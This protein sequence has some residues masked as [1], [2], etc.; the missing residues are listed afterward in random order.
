[1][2]RISPRQGESVMIYC[3]YGCTNAQ[4]FIIKYNSSD[5][6]NPEEQEN[7]HM[8]MEDTEEK[9]DAGMETAP[10]EGTETAAE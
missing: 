4:L 7:T 5:K 1:M 3:G 9:T 10:A 6:F 8:F 2:W